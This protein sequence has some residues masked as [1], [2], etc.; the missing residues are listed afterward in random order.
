MREP[1]VGGY[2]GR[3]YRLIPVRAD[4]ICRDC[5]VSASRTLPVSLKVTAYG[6][7]TEM[8]SPAAD[9]HGW[10]ADW[11]GVR[12]GASP[13]KPKH[14]HPH[15]QPAHLT[16]SDADTAVGHR[17]RPSIGLALAWQTRVQVD[18][19]SAVLCSFHAA[20]GWS[21]LA[22]TGIQGHRSRERSDHGWRHP[23]CRIRA[24]E[25]PGS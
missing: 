12:F 22:G 13:F 4:A 11:L 7:A 2:S 9:H 16:P 25:L 21:G 18:L 17:A 8:V 20:A 1:C 5:L 6:P 3:E 14:I 19:F 10:P 24:D 23:R 15:G